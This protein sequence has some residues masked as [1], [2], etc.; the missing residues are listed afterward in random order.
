MKKNLLKQTD[1]KKTI[2]ILCLVGPTG[3]GKTAAAI[4]A[5]KE[6]DGEIVNCDSRQIYRGLEI[7]T[8]QPHVSD[9]A[10]A[11]HHLYGFWDPAEILGAGAYRD[12]ALE[13]IKDIHKRGRLPILTGG[14]GLY[15]KA[16]TDG[17]AEIPEVPA[18]IKKNIARIYQQEGSAAMHGRLVKYDPVSAAR[19][20]PNDR[21]R[22]SRA[23]E[24]LA[25]TG[26]PLSEW[27]T[28]EHKGGDVE[29]VF[30][31]LRRDLNE[32]EPVL[33]AR[34]DSMIRA[35][36]LD[37]VKRVRQICADDKAPG[38]SGIGCQEILAYQRGEID[39][40]RMK[41]LWLQNTRNY[42]KRQLVWFKKESRIQWLEPENQL[43]RSF[44]L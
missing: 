36:V 6:L 32:L 31:G 27:L 23:L 15:L 30:I 18:K 33:A 26:R 17:L 35:G 12:R 13:V 4:R 1:S 42:A 2:K 37:E 3:C 21:Q 34:I 44:I 41:A 40:A 28:Q 19:L 22:I 20:H 25:A 43:K 38:L 9:L 10:Q 16:L 5:A 7:I 14:T 8:A 24:V 39:F 29:P 11:A